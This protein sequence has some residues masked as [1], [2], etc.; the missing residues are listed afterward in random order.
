MTGNQSGREDGH[1]PFGL[2]YAWWRGDPR[3]ALTDVPGLVIQRLDHEHALQADIALDRADLQTRLEQGHELYVAR[4]G[5]ETVAWGWSASQH[6]EIGELNISMTMPPGNRYLWDF[7]TLP[8]WRGQGIYGHILQAMFVDQAD[9]N[10]FWVGHDF[11]NVAS[12]RGILRAGFHLIVE[13]F[14]GDSGFYLI[15][16][17]FPERAPAA[18][19]LL[20]VPLQDTR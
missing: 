6:A 5:G 10:R 3:P 20:G 9:V 16:V 8:E 12:G 4:L 13:L 17:D 15:P 18:A 14:P 2:L 7:V 19:D 11:G 1:E